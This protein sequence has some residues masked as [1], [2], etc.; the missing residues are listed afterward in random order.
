MAMQRRLALIST[1]P[2]APAAASG[3]RRN[4][5]LVAAA[6]LL[7]AAGCPNPPLWETE[8]L[9]LGVEDDLNAMLL[10]DRASQ[11]A[12][13]YIAGGGG[14]VLRIAD[15]EAQQRRPSDV[16]LYGLAA[17]RDGLIFAVGDG[18]VVLGSADGG[19]TWER[20]NSGTTAPLRAV[21][22]VSSGAGEFIVTVGDDV[23]LV[24]PAITGRWE[25]VPP[26]EGGWGQLLALV[27]DG[28]KT[29]ALGR[30]GAL[31]S[32]SDPPA[33]WTREETGTSADLLA[34]GRIEHATTTTTTTWMGMKPTTTTTT[35]WQRGFIVVGAEGTLL[36]RSS[37]AGT[38]PMSF[39]RVDA[40]VDGDLVA[41]AG[42]YMLASDGRI[43]DAGA[44]V[45]ED[46]LVLL[47]DAA[48]D[49]RAMLHDRL[50]LTT[51]GADNVIVVGTGGQAVR[52]K[53]REL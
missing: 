45:F 32:T 25:L 30:H 42:E 29:L 15:D 1:P 13:L 9:H 8:A 26:P 21:A 11:A 37:E 19:E 28:W 7:C 41:L 31:W 3:A 4:S 27:H 10:D 43:Y 22:V 39:Q 14:L 23:V 17:T 48:I 47:G 12:A 49:A 46:D 5:T 35:E 33:D 36:V 6:L 34:G 2:A 44:L 16:A 50:G 20:L 18:G 51:A 24:R 40:G 53:P 52:L 38:I